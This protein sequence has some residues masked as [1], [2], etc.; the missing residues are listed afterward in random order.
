LF[1]FG[2]V[3]RKM[4]LKWET[5]F[6]KMWSFPVAVVVA[7]SVERTAFDMAVVAVIVVVVVVVVVVVTTV[8]GDDD[9]KLRRFP[10]LAHKATTSSM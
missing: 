8:M 1:R 5:M 2:I 10:S 9:H 7:V 6:L 4:F 3:E